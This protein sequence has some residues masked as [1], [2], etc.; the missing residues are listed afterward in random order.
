[1]TDLFTPEGHL[2]DEALKALVNDELDELGRLEAGEHLSF[3]DHCLDR[4]MALLTPEV[5]EE[6][7]TD[8]V[9]PVMRKNSSRARRQTLRRWASAAAAV[10]IGSTLFYTGVFQQTSEMLQQ[11]L[12]EVPPQS[13]AE[14]FQKPEADLGNAILKAVDEW[15]IWVRQKAAPAYR[16]PAQ[17]NFNET[18]EIGG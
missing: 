8:L 2:T 9:L 14:P 7:E 4:Y 1:M 6:P 3:C 11:R 13:Q 17:R 15:S 5:L 16:A 18:N 12:P 10:A